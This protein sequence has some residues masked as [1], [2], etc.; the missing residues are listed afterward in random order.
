MSILLNVL[1]WISLIIF[2][3]AYNFVW[4]KTQ[5][6]DAMYR[7]QYERIKVRLG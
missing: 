4:A 6:S 5:H 1:D 3:E 2:S 7:H